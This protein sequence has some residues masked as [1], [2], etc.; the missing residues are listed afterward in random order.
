[1]PSAMR[2][3]TAKHSKTRGSLIKAAQN[4]IKALELRLEG[5]S[6]EYIGNILGVSKMM[7]SKYLAQSIDELSK[8]ELPLADQ[9]RQLMLARLDL[10]LTK[11]KPKIDEGNPRAIIVAVDIESR[12]AKLLG[13]DKPI[14]VDHSGT[15]NV[16]YVNDWRTNAIPAECKAIEPE[17]KKKCGRP[18]KKKPG[19]EIACDT[20]DL[21]I[22]ASDIDFILD[23][24]GDD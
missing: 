21:D 22:D 8:T 17:D 19:E 23:E 18:K 4:R 3:L 24:E 16:A 1:M 2:M 10:Y 15:I 20:E 6:C 12:R 11:L 14:E 7:V 5:N 13:L 9:R